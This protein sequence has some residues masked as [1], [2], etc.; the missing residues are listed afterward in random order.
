MKLILVCTYKTCTLSLFFFYSKFLPL[1]VK[2]MQSFKS[3]QW[4]SVHNLHISKTQKWMH[5]VLLHCRS[6]WSV[7][8][9]Y[10]ALNINILKFELHPT[11]VDPSELLML[12]NFCSWGSCKVTWGMIQTSSNSSRTAWTFLRK[13]RTLVQDRDLLHNKLYR[14][15][16]KTL[17]GYLLNVYF[18]A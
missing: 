12:K 6:L 16:N 7:V 3:A 2:Y 11:C 15:C 13:Y 10:Q 4:L 8:T 17:I 9:K 1:T 14:P 5:L 18:L